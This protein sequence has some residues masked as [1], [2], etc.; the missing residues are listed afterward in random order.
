MMRIA[1]L[2]SAACCLLS[3]ASLAG[4]TE[5]ERLIAILRSDRPSNERAWACR[6]LKFAGTAAS[7]PALAEC[8]AD[9][10]LAHS[11]RYALE[12]MPFPE[13]AAA[14]RDAVPKTAGLAKAGII[15]SIGDRRDKEAVPLLAPLAAD[16]DPNV[17][18]SASVALGKIG[19]PEAIAALEAARPKAPDAAKQAVSDGLLLCADHLLRAG[20]RAAAAALF[21]KINQPSEPEHIRSAALL[22]VILAAGNDADGLVAKGLAGDDRAAQL[23]SLAALHE[24]KGPLM[25]RASAAVLKVLAP[26][27]QVALIQVLAQR[28]DL[29]AAPAIIDA[30]KSVNA[31][32]RAAA[33]HA[34]GLLGSPAAVPV[35][36]EAAAKGEGAIQETAREALARISGKGIREALAARLGHPDPAIQ[37]E[38]VRALGAR[39][40]T[41]AVPALLKLAQGDDAAARATA[42]RSLATLAD[43][44]AIDGLLALMPGAEAADA[45]AIER[46]LAAV[47]SRSKRPEAC[48]AP[49]LAAM[50]TAPAPMRARL[51]RAIGRLDAPEAIAALRAAIEDKEPA[52]RDAAIRT[53]AENAGL[54]AAPDLLRL[55]TGTPEPTHRILAVRGLWRLIALAADRP[56]DERWKMSQA[57][58]AASTRPDEKKLGLT[59]LAKLPHPGALKLAEALCADPAVKAE[60]EAAA[61]RL[62][63]S[64]LGTHRAE[65]KATLQRLAAGGNAAARK[66][67]D[68]LDQHAG[69]I[70]AWQVAGPY[71]QQGKQCRELFDI[72]FAPEQPDAKV[73]WKALPPPADPALFWQADLL[74]VADGEQCVVYIRSRVFVPRET[75]ARLEIGSD[76]GIKLWVNGKL[77]H[78]NNVM[79]PI[80]AGQDK[81][82]ATLRE[83]WN[84]FLLKVTQNNMGFAACVR[85][86][87]AD[88][89]PI[90]GL[91]SQAHGVP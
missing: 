3:T 50:K 15:D 89:S 62:A 17:A 78:A 55:A 83:G 52:V 29:E 28:G 25:T 61:V 58:F 32:V 74:P 14:L 22:G 87:N 44:S 11:A 12:A 16:A 86:R 72:P 80:V 38:I 47:C 91:R 24:L 7:V 35:L 63:A 4:E 56:L 34:L 65:A 21:K 82:E 19:G 26:R 66:A 54:E 9:K 71:R 2:L 53:L 69:F 76:D 64:L 41:A 73:D 75:K 90:E 84:D 33:L 49:I 5:E 37:A 18:S 23:A 81:A 42:L 45:E 10:E 39:R 13:A 70:T 88:A 8:L 85:L 59:E 77:A 60:A 27:L 36:A 48:T 43:E 57:A 6:R 40:D 68:A 51:I 46:A 67:L 31:A 20:D 30:A 1:F 79:R